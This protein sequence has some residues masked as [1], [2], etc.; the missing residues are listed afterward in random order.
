MFLPKIKNLM[1]PSIS[2]TGKLIL[3][4]AFLLGLTTFYGCVSKKKYAELEGLKVACEKQLAEREKTATVTQL[5]EYGTVVSLLNMNVLYRGLD[6]PV[7]IAV[8]GVDSRLLSVSM[9]GGVITRNEDGTYNV[10]PGEGKEA[11]IYVSANINGE[12]VS[13]PERYFRVKR[14]PDPV[15]SFGGKKPYDSIIALGDAAAAAGVRAGM[16][17]FDFPVMARVTSFK[18]TLFTKNMLY[19]YLCTSNRISEDASNAI[20]QMKKGDRILIEGIMCLMPDN[21]ELKLQN[22][23]LTVI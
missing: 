10:R 8:P 22:I 12:I 5:G 7:E 15:P 9:E 23:V 11:I 17:G 6:N 4:F 18:V 2:L 1:N 16:E 14:I 19:E 3:Q 21:S 20:R 13:M